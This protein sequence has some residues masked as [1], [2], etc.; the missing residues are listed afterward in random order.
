MQV[1]FTS[2]VNTFTHDKVVL[3]NSVQYKLNLKVYKTLT[4]D[5]VP[6]Q[7]A[8]PYKILTIKLVNM[9]NTKMQELYDFML[10]YNNTISTVTTV[11]GSET[12]TCKGYIKNNP[13]EFVNMGKD[14][15]STLWSITLTVEGEI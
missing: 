4:G 15:C 5:I 3:G 13:N 6:I 10:S 7:I 14:K 8:E 2:G 1:T 12:V 11:D 9:S